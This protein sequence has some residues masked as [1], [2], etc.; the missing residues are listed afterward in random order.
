MKKRPVNCNRRNY[1]GF[2]FLEQPK[3]FFSDYVPLSLSS[4]VLM[5][6]MPTSS[7]W[8]YSKDSVY[9]YSYFW[10]W[11]VNTEALWGAIEVNQGK[12]AR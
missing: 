6:G 7:I 4:P 11:C 9:L 2:Q 8:L 12:R 10:I 1:I 3:L 5:P